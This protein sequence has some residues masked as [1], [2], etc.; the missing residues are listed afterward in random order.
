MKFLY[1]YKTSDGER[2]EGEIEAA[3]R[4][5]AFEMLRREG[6]RPIKVVS[7]NGSRANGET[8][9]ITRKSF[10]VA[11]LIAGLFIGG[12]VAY[13]LSRTDFRDLRLVELERRGAEIVARHEKMVGTLHLEALRNY[14]EIFTSEGSWMLNQKISLSQFNFKETRQKLKELFKDGFEIFPPETNPKEWAE[15]ERIYQRMMD[16][17]DIGEA[18]IINDE[19]AFRLLD[20]NRG[21]WKVKDGCI[22]WTDPA[23]AA[24]FASYTRELKE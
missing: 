5:V 24:D 13:L 15:V 4:D 22:E 21:K 11:A 18:R 8:K 19:K 23:L 1:A 16:T 20:S 9:F 10:V 14:R 6:I 17:V 2:H 7:A 12:I 3:S